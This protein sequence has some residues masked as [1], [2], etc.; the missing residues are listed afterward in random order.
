VHR[1]K[2]RVIGAVFMTFGAVFMTFGAVFMTFGALHL[3]MR[4]FHRIG[5]LTLTIRK[6]KVWIMVRCT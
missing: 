4:N 2:V 1:T 6:P 3:G 5:Q